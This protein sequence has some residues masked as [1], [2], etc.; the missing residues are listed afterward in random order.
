ME[1]EEEEEE[2]KEIKLCSVTKSCKHKES[3]TYVHV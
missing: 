1:E 3:Y 2:E